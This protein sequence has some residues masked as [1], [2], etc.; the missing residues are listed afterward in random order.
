MTRSAHRADRR[1]PARLSALAA[2]ATATACVLAAA[3]AA[4]AVA[5]P[6]PTPILP[7]QFF[8]GLVNGQ[9]T[10]A[11]ILVAC[12]GSTG[13]PVAGQ[14]FSARQVSAPT[15]ASDGFTGTAAKTVDAAV[16]GDAATVPVQLRT[17][18]ELAPIPTS[19]IL[20]C[21]GTGTV[22]FTPDPGSP[23]A[24][25]SVVKVA[26]VSESPAKPTPAVHRRG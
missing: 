2:V 6:L 12:D 22:V 7:N 24:V 20:P 1:R 17:Y 13:H 8:T 23:T 21:A 14:T 18:G 10:L 3:P 25:S 11:H 5:G 15:D 19:L 16:S 4:L 26:F 9:N